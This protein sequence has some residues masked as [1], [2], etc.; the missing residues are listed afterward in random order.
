MGYLCQVGSRVMKRA[1]AC[2]VACFAL[3]SLPAQADH[4]HWGSPYPARLYVGVGPYGYWPGPGIGLGY[5][6]AHPHGHGWYAA[7]SVGIRVGLGSR[8]PRRVVAQSPQPPAAEKLFVYPAAGQSEQQA[9]DDRYECHVWASD[10]SGY[11]PTLG[12]G[13]AVEVDEYRR[14]F[15]ACLEGCGYVVK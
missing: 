8:A 11:D 6:Y 4:R 3:T 12:R 15:I 2:L 5:V 13:S 14:A 9:A 10:R 1:I 7:P